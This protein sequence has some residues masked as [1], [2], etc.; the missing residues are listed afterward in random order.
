ME[1]EIGLGIIY[2]DAQPYDCFVPYGECFRRPEER[3]IIRWYGPT[4]AQFN[5]V[6]PFYRKP[7]VNKRREK[8]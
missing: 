8:K 7:V 4:R 2:S 6:V 3:K 5:L 1:I